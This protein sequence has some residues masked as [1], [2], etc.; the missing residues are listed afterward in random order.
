MNNSTSFFYLY[1][2]HASFISHNIWTTHLSV[3]LLRLISF[4]TI[5]ILNRKWSCSNFRDIQVKMNKKS[6]GN[7]FIFCWGITWKFYGVVYWHL[8][9][10]TDNWLQK[11]LKYI[12]QE[13][14]E[15]DT[16]TGTLG[17]KLSEKKKHKSDI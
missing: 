3:S 11:M 14:V 5:P 7:Q 4:M 13:W 17:P 2:F 9:C 1:K 10:E 16:M 6:L 8:S 12:G 15:S